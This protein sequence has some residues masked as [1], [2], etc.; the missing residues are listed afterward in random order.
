MLYRLL[1]ERAES[2]PD[3][4]AI[5]GERRS[6]TFSQVHDETTRVA[7][8]LRTDLKLKAEDPLIIGV[9]GSPEF[10]TL[11]YG[12]AAI[13]A[14]AVPV[15]PS[16]K[17]PAPIKAMAPATVAGDADFLRA[18][19]DAGLTVRGVIVWDRQNGLHLPDRPAALDRRKLIRKERV[20]AA[21]S[22]GTTGEPTLS[23]RTAELLA[24]SWELGPAVY[25]VAPEDVFL[26][27]R[28]FSPSTAIWPLAKGGKIV[29][30]EKFGRLSMAEAIAR[31]RVTILSSGPYFY[32]LLASIPVDD[33]ADFSSLRLCFCGGAPLPRAVFDRFYRRFGLRIRQIYAGTQIAPALS[34]SLS[35]SIPE[36]AGHV[37][38]R[39]PMAVLDDEGNVMGPGKVGEIVVDVAGVKDTLLRSYLR[40]N[41]RR[42]G[43]YLYSGD[44]GKVDA[45]GNLY[46]VGRKGPL[47]KVGGFRVSP[48]EV[49][50]VLR[51]HPGVREVLV[52]P[53]NPGGIKELVGALIVPAGE[54]T[55]EELSR[56][57]A[58]RLEW[59]KCPH[60]IEFRE[61]LPRN[62]G[63]KV[64]PYL[65]SSPAG[66]ATGEDDS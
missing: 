16:G 8:F 32:D 62:A 42:R 53:V 31:E 52:F 18:V 30:R 44:L 17:I 4:I 55:Q 35:D 51:S 40:R 25:Q 36:A 6:V 19:E 1:C 63:G 23:F 34:Y 7:H 46:V 49:E 59:F 14:T 47:I 22:S 27:T 66:P 50:D 12:A 65:F 15:S 28:L 3:K 5:A 38:G 20:F 33:S 54:V 64:L 29:V 56:H 57:C 9:P 11:F 61:S 58:E 41:P 37:T 2:Y 13:G 10:C 48:A 45:E 24:R 39:F 26:S 43:R 21:S 60:T